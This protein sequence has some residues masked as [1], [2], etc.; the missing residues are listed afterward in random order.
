MYSGN[1]FMRIRRV[2]NALTNIL[3]RKMLGHERYARRIGVQI[4][5]NCDIGSSNFGSEP[6]LI[7]IGNRVQISDSVSFFTHGGSWVLRK[8]DPSFDIFGKIAIKDNVYIGSHAAILPG[9]IIDN[10]CIIGAYSVVTKSVP[11]GVIVAGNP[12]KIISDVK[13]YYNR[14]KPYNTS[15][16]GFGAKNKEKILLSQSTN[17]FINKK[18]M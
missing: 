5:E 1:T 16:Y 11:T 14:M 9:V 15:T 13:S 12:A 6:Y 3:L 18:S 4:G 17:K 2:A 10:D 8:R 7:T